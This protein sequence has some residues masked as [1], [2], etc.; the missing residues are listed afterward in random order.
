MPTP[1]E[2]L[3]E[4]LVKGEIT[5]EQH[6]DLKHRLQAAGDDARTGTNKPA[7][8]FS[9]DDQPRLNNAM[10]SKNAW[11]FIATGIGLILIMSSL[12]INA[13]RMGCDG[14]FTA[15]CL[16]KPTLFGLMLWGIGFLL[17]LIGILKLAM[18]K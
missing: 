10:S 11:S 3:D 7:Q 9:I 13:V 1:R 2:I 6:D 8:L 16:Y 12:A 15:D 14:E 5:V 17:L 4:R 18:R